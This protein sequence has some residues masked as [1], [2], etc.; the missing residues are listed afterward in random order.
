MRKVLLL[1]LVLS[2]TPATASQTD[3][4]VTDP[5]LHA[6]KVPALSLDPHPVHPSFMQQL[7]QKAAAKSPTKA[8]GQRSGPK[9][10]SR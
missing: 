9:L 6:S 8:P 2:G 3:N 1:P 5:S 10:C 4:Y 7:R